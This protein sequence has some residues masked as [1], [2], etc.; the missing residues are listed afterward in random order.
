MYRW[1]YTFIS[2]SLSAPVRTQIIKENEDD[3]RRIAYSLWHSLEEEYALPKTQLRY[4]IVVD[5]MSFATKQHD[6]VH[7]LF[8]HFLGVTM[9]D[10]VL[11]DTLFAALPTKWRDYA[12]KKIEK[13]QTSKSSAI[14]LDINLLMDEIRSRL[15]PQMEDEKLTLN[16]TDANAVQFHPWF[17]PWSRTWWT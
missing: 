8:D 4:E 16:T 12:Q 13:A 9:P 15:A 14:V 11:F 1:L 7:S 6:D 10:S 2:S 3:R 17:Y 5:F